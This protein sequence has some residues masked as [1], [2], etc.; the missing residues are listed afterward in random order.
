MKD[1]V[2]S[3]KDGEDEDGAAL[4]INIGKGERKCRAPVAKATRQQPVNSA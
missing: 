3:C 4:N 1:A 2:C